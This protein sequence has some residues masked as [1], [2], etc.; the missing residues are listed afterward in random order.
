[1]NQVVKINEHVP[2]RFN[3][4]QI[5]L[6][7]RQ[8]CV[9]GTDDELK[10]F[11]HQAQRSGL[12]PLARQIYAI[13]RGGKMTI[14]V[15]IDGFRLIA[16]RSG[17]Y[18][19]QLGPHWCGADGEWTD[20]WLVKEPP[21]AAR[22]GVLRSD[23]KEPCWAVSRW[24]SY[25]QP[26]NSMWQKMPDLMLAKTAEALALRKAFPQDLSG[27]YTFDEMAQAQP[28]ETVTMHPDGR[29]EWPAGSGPHNAPPVETI[30]HGGPATI[31][32]K[33]LADLQALIFETAGAR[34]LHLEARLR[35]YMKVEALADI[36]AS[37][38]A[39]AVS[40]VEGQRKNYE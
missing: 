10:M 15:S 17:K 40:A 33:Q 23:F 29:P 1:M 16:E 7:K 21:A 9:G 2:S 13:K 35:K 37:E 22:V 5:A 3:D 20:A 27:L 11:L 8:V 36:L 39:D 26:N 25:A 12:D 30:E 34:S 32:E 31:N 18:A 14:Q 24:S 6:I 4:E 28:A 38:Y 19:G